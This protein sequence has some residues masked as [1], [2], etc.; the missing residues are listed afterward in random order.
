LPSPLTLEDIARLSG[1]SRSTVSRV[2]NGD[3][4]VSPETR[5]R[6]LDVIEANH[7]QPNLA[8]RGLAAG[9]TRVIG[10]VIPQ[11][12]GLIFSDPFFSPLIQ[13]ISA[14]CNRL[15]YSAMMWLADPEY[16]RRTIGRLL[17]NGLIDG[18][19]V[20]SMENDDPIVDALMR[21]ARPFVLVGRHSQTEPVSFVDVDNRGGAQAAVE[22]LA[23]HGYRRIATITGPQ[24]MVAGL[25][26]LNGYR[27]AL[28]A[29]GLPYD[30]DRVREGDFSDSSGYAAMQALLSAHPDAVFIASDAMATG[31][32][33]ALADA[34]LRV[35]E[36]IALVGFDDIPT[37]CRTNP[38][39][40]TVRQP[41]QQVGQL[42]AELLIRRIQNP[43]EPPQSIVLPT[44]L[45]VR[46]SCGL[47]H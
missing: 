33:A 7:F 43:A 47:T 2:V 14:A 27:A 18:V 45:V 35:P 23:G 28:E 12:L 31:A 10:M 40:T 20:S 22:H 11:G 34:G 8:A 5:S 4:A 24:N 38:P 1:V 25:D 26:R 44:Q 19:I 16:E 13:S 9:R 46:Q 17:H 42:A 3:P 41:I 6:V 30:P 37:T 32:L 21:S 36:D 15:D 29:A 39:L